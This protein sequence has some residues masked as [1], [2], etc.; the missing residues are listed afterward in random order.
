[1]NL[2]Y[3]STINS[4]KSLCG[5]QGPVI[6]QVVAELHIIYNWLTASPAKS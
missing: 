2:Q 5:E 3:K 4:F 6:N 1:M